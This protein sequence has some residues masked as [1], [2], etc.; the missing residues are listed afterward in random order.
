MLIIRFQ[1]KPLRLKQKHT[2]NQHSLYFQC[3]NKKF[4]TK[5]QRKHS[6]IKRDAIFYSIQKNGFTQKVEFCLILH[7]IEHDPRVRYA[8][9]RQSFARIFPLH[10]CFLSSG[11]V[12]KSVWS[13]Q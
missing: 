6:P 10:W 2:Q 7:S 4:H 1:E 13:N 5:K 3:A 9:R 12:S 8:D 11:S